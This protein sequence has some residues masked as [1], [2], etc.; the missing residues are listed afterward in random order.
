MESEFD[1]IAERYLTLN[2]G[3]EDRQVRIALGRPYQEPDQSYFCPYRITGVGAELARRAG[4]VDGIQAIQLALVIIGGELS[5]Y[6]ES[7]KWDGEPTTGFPA[8]IHDPA[9]GTPRA[10]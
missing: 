5:R 9:G 1:V 2:A 4:G 8:S 10:D 3:G 7:L 6:S